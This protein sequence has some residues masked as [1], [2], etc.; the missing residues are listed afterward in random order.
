LFP[1]PRFDEEDVVTFGIMKNS[2]GWTVGAGLGFAADYAF[3]SES[4]D[5]GGEVGNREKQHGLIGGGIILSAFVF[6]AYENVAGNKFCVMAGGFIGES[7]SE[8]IAVE[9]LRA[10]KLVEIQLDAHDLEFCS[11]RHGLP[12]DDILR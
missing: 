9:F 12:P 6:E 5:G 7:E 1:V 2:P 8:N 4:F 11:L 10:S 3:A